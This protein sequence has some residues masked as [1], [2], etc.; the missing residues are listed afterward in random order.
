MTGTA[1]SKQQYDESYPAGIEQLFW[2]VA[3]NFIIRSWLANSGM[4]AAPL[5]EIGCGRGIIVDYLRRSGLDCIGCDLADPPVPPHLAG[6]L[7]PS[8]DFRALPALTRQ[9]IKGVLLCDVLEHIPEQASLLASLADALPALSH[10][11]ITVPARAELWSAWDDYYGHFRRYDL[12]MLR[13]EI[14]GADLTLV[15]QR[16]FF[17]ALYLPMLLTRGRS[18]RTEIAAP[19]R[20]L[21]HRLV[22]AGFIAESSVVP[23][24]VPGTSIIAV[25]HLER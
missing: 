13:R 22:G 4:N 5:L 15:K 20:A 14:E 18:R 24:I 19:A 3:R 9:R 11:L 10:V 2:H 7:F 8:T 25:C 16:Y 1:Y 23:S 12:T 6:V 17:H 21:L